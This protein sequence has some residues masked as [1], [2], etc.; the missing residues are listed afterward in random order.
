M[1]GYGFGPT[2]IGTTGESDIGY[3]VVGGSG[4]IDIAALGNGRILQLALPDAML[5]AAP[6]GPPKYAP[7]DYENTRDGNGLV[8]VSLA[9][10]AWVPLQFGGLNKALFTAATTKLLALKSSDGATFVD[11]MPLVILIVLHRI[12]PPVQSDGAGLAPPRAAGVE[13]VAVN[14]A[15]T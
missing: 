2:G 15:S 12:V 3:G 8:Y 1:N 11:M 14:A 5:T 7:N 13:T 6:K 4:G 9:G 10:G